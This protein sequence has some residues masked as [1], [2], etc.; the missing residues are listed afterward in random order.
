MKDTYAVL[1]ASILQEPLIEAAKSLQKKTIVFDKNPKAV[2]AKKADTFFAISISDIESIFQALRPYQER[3][4][5]VVTLGTDQT[6]TMSTLNQKLGLSSYPPEVAEVLSHKGKMRK[7]FKGILLQPDF[8]H[9]SKTDENLEI[10]QSWAKKHPSQ[11]GYVVKPC[12]NMGARGVLYIPNEN[13][14]EMAME[15]AFRFSDEIIIEHYI[16]A[17]EISVDAL[18]HEGEVCLTG[19]A[20]RVIEKYH[21]LFF[22]ERGHILPAQSSLQEKTNLSY[23]MMQKIVKAIQ[24]KFGI[25]YTGALK[26]DFR[27]L[28]KEKKLVLG[29]VAGRLSGGFMSTHTFYYATGYSLPKAYLQLSAGKKPDIF[30]KTM[31]YKKISAE[32]SVAGGFGKIKELTYPRKLGTIQNIFTMKQ[33]GDFVY[34]LKSNVGKILHVVYAADSLKEIEV[35]KQK[36]E[37]EIHIHLNQSPFDKQEIRKQA[38]KNFNPAACWVC[39]EC[40]GMNCAS[41]V[42]GMGGAGNMETFANNLRAIRKYFVKPRYVENQSTDEIQSIH[43]QISILGRTYQAPILSAPITGAKTN[44][45]SSTTELEYALNTAIALKANG[46]LPT[47]GDGAS[48]FKYLT[49]LKVIESIQDGI[50]F[51]KPRSHLEEVQKRIIAAEAAGAIAWGMDIDGLGFKTMQLKKQATRRYHV[52]ELHRLKQTSNLPMVLKGILSVEDALLAA[53]AGADII[54]V[55]NHGGRVMDRLPATA[56]VLPIIVEAFKKENITIPIFVDGG[57]RSG[58]D[59]FIML[60]LGASAVLIGRPIVIAEVAYHEIGVSSY[61]QRICEELKQ[62]MFLAGCSDLASIQKK[63]ILMKA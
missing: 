35:A 22:I 13:F 46:L 41:S 7:F 37:Q 62:S 8:L 39:R 44:M 36:F 2:G 54:I 12:K 29:E 55:S 3:L 26:G 48:P 14:F 42:P 17:E 11:M 40:D 15:Y 45:G 43:T 61:V 16:E 51:F 25:R 19:V 56:D 53:E 32:F 21:N 60:A 34:D 59:V 5:S 6:F 52:K 18:V 58:Q 49:G 47:F 27:F 20:D 63:H 28:T 38:K 50:P 1:G 24:E 31:E 57:I 10:V 33:K 23:E 4:I 30:N 9:V